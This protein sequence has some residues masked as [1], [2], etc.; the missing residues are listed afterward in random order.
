VCSL[1]QLKPEYHLISLTDTKR[2]YKLK[3]DDLEYLT[4]HEIENGVYGFCTYFLLRDVEEYYEEKYHI[5]LSKAPKICDVCNTNYTQ[6]SDKH[7][8][9]FGK[10]I[11]TSC[12]LKP[13]YTLICLADVKD[14]YSL[15]KEDLKDL[16]RYTSDH[17]FLGYY[18]Y[19]LLEDIKKL[20]DNKTT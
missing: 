2:E 7:E 14:K 16:P 19:F 8:F 11:C 5:L 4:R 3:E 17:D 9:F 20:S 18:S 15:K 13:E 10:R 12:Q 6:M 1:C